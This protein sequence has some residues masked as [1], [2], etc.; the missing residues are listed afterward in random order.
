[1]CAVAK[2]RGISPTKLLNLWVQEKLR[3]ETI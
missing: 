2:R 3:D 1:M